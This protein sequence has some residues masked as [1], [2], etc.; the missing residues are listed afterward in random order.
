MKGEH[1]KVL[2]LPYPLMLPTDLLL[3][4]GISVL[5]DLENVTVLAYFMLQLAWSL[6]CGNLK[7]NN[8]EESFIIICLLRDQIHLQ[9]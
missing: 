2:M 7:S 4:K 9:R 8:H 1:K 6:S 3:V 5:K